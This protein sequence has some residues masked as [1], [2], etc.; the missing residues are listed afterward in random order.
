[1]IKSPGFA[2]VLYKAQKYASIFRAREAIG[3][4]A[5]IIGFGSNHP[6]GGIGMGS[7]DDDLE[8]KGMKVAA[9]SVVG[10]S[11]F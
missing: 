5:L 10:V 9:P 8:E 6:G 11:L 3:S 2:F 1:M 7:A 4:S